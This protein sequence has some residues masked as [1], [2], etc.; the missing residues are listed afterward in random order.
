MDNPPPLFSNHE[1]KK[2]PSKKK[3]T[4]YINSHN[5]IPI[6]FRI[7]GYQAI[8]LDGSCMNQCYF[9]KLG[10]PFFSKQSNLVRFFYI[11]LFIF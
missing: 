8:N 5:M 11:N 7:V 9:G 4:F 3:I 1:G 6:R 10:A 2:S